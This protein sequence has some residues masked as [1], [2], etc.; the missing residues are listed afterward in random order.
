[1]SGLFVQDLTCVFLQSPLG[2]LC[3]ILIS[4]LQDIQAD[5]ARRDWK[6]LRAKHIQTLQDWI[7]ADRREQSEIESQTAEYAL[8]ED[9]SDDERDYMLTL[10]Q[11][12]RTLK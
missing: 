10:F 4:C 3:P 5:E 11:S 1:M 7:A 8:D 6:G 9:Y 2:G 12:Q